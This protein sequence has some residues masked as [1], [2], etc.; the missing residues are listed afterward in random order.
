[1]GTF[2]WNDSIKL[3]N[4]PGTENTHGLKVNIAFKS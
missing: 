1:V 3:I 2:R 4:I